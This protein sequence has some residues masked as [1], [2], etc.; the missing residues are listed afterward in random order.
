LGHPLAGIEPFGDPEIHQQRL[1]AGPL[2][3]DVLGLDVAMQQTHVVRMLQRV[4]HGACQRRD[5]LRWQCAFPPQHIRQRLT[6]H[7]R[8]RVVHDA[9]SLSHEMDGEH[10][11]MAEAGDGLGL[12]PKP[13]QHSRRPRDVGPQ[14]LYREPALQLLVP[15]LVDL[16]EPTAAQQPADLILR[17][18]RG[19]EPCLNL[20][21]G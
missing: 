1:A 19:G 14:H 3:H 13:L 11:G 8:H 18:Q 10:V 17:A 2:D 15:H 6:F 21:P 20:R 4:E 16:G 7:E 12:L 5:P 9:V